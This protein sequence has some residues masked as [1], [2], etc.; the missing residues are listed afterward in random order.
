MQ[1]WFK[2]QYGYVNVDDDNFYL[3][4]SGNWT[5][6]LKLEEK[7]PD[8]AF[9][10]SFRPLRIIIYFICCIALFSW[11]LMYTFSM[12]EISLLLIAALA[13]GSYFLWQYLRAEM[14]TAF[15]IPTSKITRVEIAGKTAVIQ[16]NNEKNMPDQVILKKVSKR[17]LEI[18]ASYNIK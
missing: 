7:N 2:H 4:N 10:K 16:F 13:G 15:K 12:G 5:E 1:D 9:K 14:S 18:L 6:A 11:F 8:S 17:G 3:T